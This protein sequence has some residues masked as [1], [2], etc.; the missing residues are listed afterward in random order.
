MATP[1]A[2]N[3][4]ALSVHHVTALVVDVAR[5]TAWYR[6]NLGFR[7]A[8]EGTRM[9]GKMKFAELRIPGFGISLVQLNLPALEVTPGQL[10]RPAWA[11]I[12]FAVADPDG[13]YH[14]L[15]DKGLHVTTREPE[16]NAPVKT[17]LLYDSE[18]T[19]IEI[20]AAGS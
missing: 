12:A 19:E 8:Q 18:G 14:R 11:H 5:A 16:T 7:V 6:D 2:E 3:P 9:D 4:Y 17:F 20:V 1:A 13:L 10:V 15:K